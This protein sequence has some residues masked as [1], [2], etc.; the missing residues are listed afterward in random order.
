M[1]RI[2]SF[3]GFLLAIAL[4][5]ATAPLTG[6]SGLRGPGFHDD[7]WS[8]GLRPRDPINHEQWGFSTKARQIESNVGIR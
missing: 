1:A 2:R 4:T 5:L 6:C 3:H 8:T 7:N